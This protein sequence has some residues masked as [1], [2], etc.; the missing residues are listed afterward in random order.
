MITEQN[1][2]DAIKDARDGGYAGRKYNQRFWCGSECCVYGFARI[3][4]GMPEVN[5]G[6]QPGELEDT[7]RNRMF[8]ALMSIGDPSVLDV[9]EAVQPD[10]SLEWGG[11]LFLNG[12]TELPKGATIS[13]AWE[14]FLCGLTSL[15]AGVTLRAGHRVWLNDLIRLEPGAV[16]PP[17]AY[18]PL[19]QEEPQ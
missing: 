15:P 18:A 19:L 9:M 7:P 17:N 6:P 1:I 10:G 14:L 5:G 11:N 13:A 12:L 3:R 2:L 8:A 16:L 4:A